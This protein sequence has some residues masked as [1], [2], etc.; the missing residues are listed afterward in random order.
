M[1][2]L[3]LSL[4]GLIMI[5]C[6]GGGSEAGSGPEATS[7]PAEQGV[8]SADLLL[9]YQRSG[10]FAGFDDRLLVY[11]DGRASLTRRGVAARDV[12]LEPAT[13][14]ALR[15]AVESDQFC[16]LPTTAL[17]T[18]PG[19]DRFTSVVTSYG[20]GPPHSVT[21]ADGAIPPG[22]GSVLELLDQIVVRVVS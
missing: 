6:Q 10:G 13:V 17:P 14:D 4:F 9:E 15:A 5:T 18:R 21:T 22:M 16:S 12:M 8:A 2:G 7:A 20:C 11:G 1:Y 19:A 3:L